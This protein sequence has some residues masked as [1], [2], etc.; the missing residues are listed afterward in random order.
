MFP[1]FGMIVCMNASVYFGIFLP[2]NLPLPSGGLGPPFSDSACC[3]CYATSFLILSPLGLLPS[4]IQINPQLQRDTSAMLW[5]I[6]PSY[7][8]HSFLIPSQ[9]Y[10]HFSL[11][12]TT[13]YYTTLQNLPALEADIP[14]TKNYFFSSSSISLT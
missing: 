14:L 9:I 12:T 7:T 11:P 6:I 8:Q 5:S 2:T 3:V 4:S 10:P 13:F 1:P